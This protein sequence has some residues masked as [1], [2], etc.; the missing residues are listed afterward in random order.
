[1]TDERLLEAAILI[2]QEHDAAIEHYRAQG[3]IGP[4]VVDGTRA[5]A[6]L[7]AVVRAVM[8]DRA[9]ASGSVNLQIDPERWH[10]ADVNPTGIPVRAQR[11]DG[12]WTTTDIVALDAASL[13]VWL[14][15]RGG[16][17]S[18]AED[19]VRILLG[20]PEPGVL[21]DR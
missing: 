16:E 6:S 9:R 15:S 21:E 5:I 2:L 11:S 12:S 7:R 13:L 18:W 20:H 1:M 17:N 3:L 14:R 8:L 10:L 19:V 4:E